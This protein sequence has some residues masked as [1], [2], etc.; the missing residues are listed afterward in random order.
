MKRRTLVT[1][2]EYSVMT[3]LSLLYIAGND[4]FRLVIFVL[5][6]VC[7]GDYMSRLYK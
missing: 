7:S 2:I 5:L 4:G 3:V 1:V 6:L